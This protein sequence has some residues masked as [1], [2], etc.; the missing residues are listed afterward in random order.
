MNML[1]PKH[2]SIARLNIKKQKWIKTAINSEAYSSFE[3]VASRQRI[4]LEMIHLSLCRNK[5]KQVNM[6]NMTGPYLPIVIYAIK[7]QV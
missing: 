2:K 3:G 7:K 1:T 4:A 5:N 6:Y